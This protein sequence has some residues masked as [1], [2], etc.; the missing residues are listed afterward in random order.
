[1][2]VFIDGNGKQWTVSLTVGSAKRAAAEC[3]A[4]FFTLTILPPGE[5]KRLP[6][7]DVIRENHAVFTKVLYSL[8]RDQAGR[9]GVTEKNFA[10]LIQGSVLEN[11]INA[12]TD[13]ILNFSRP[14]KRKDYAGFCGRTKR[15]SP[16]NLKTMSGTLAES[17]ARKSAAPEYCGESMLQPELFT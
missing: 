6:L 13:E 7:T 11:A 15:F 1:M 2:K 16:R 12:V 10:G 4:D 5:N 17:M 3:G 14:A 9:A 8:C